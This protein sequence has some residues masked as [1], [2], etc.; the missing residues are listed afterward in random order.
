MIKK[1][2]PKALKCTVIQKKCIF[3]DKRA[4]FLGTFSA[5]ARGF[6]K[7]KQLPVFREL[8]HIQCELL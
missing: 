2:C 1:F 5:P 8:F 3:C 7:K 6:L 4:L